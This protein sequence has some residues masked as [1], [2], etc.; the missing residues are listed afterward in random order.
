M[1]ILES[2]SQ[3]TQAGAYT[4]G[5]GKRNSGYSDHAPV[6]YRQEMRDF[7]RYVREHPRVTGI[8]E[9]RLALVLGHCDSFVGHFIDWLPQ[10]GQF[11]QARTNAN[12]LYGTP[13]RSWLAA[14]NVLFPTPAGATGPY[15]NAWLGGSPFGQVDICQIDRLTTI[16]DLSKYKG[17]AYAGWN[18]MN[19]EITAVLSQY[20]QQGGRLL[21]CLPHLSTRLDREY[22]RYD[23]DDLIGNGNLLALVPVTVKGSKSLATQP[24]FADKNLTAPAPSVLATLKD[25]RVADVAV[26]PDAEVLCGTPDAPVVVRFRQ[27]R[28]EIIL[29]LTWE[30]PGKPSIAGLYQHLLAEFAS[31][32]HGEVYVTETGEAEPRSGPNTAFIAYATYPDRT[33]LLNM[34]TQSPHSFWLHRGTQTSLLTLRPA[35][36]REAQSPAR[37]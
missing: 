8:P 7:Y 37:N 14:Q 4:K 20:V 16:D 30:Y 22:R 27:G 32:L 26:G 29:L 13:E 15:A 33:Y 35:E 18:S 21:I 10:W 19:T 6:R 5:S 31:S 1:I 34:D 23:V 24:T 25:E 3:T 28:G 9:S 11:A 2:A 36:L 17:L 12:W